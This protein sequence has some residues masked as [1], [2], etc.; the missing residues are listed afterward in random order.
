M[1]IL[2]YW[3]SCEYILR[4]FMKYFVIEI[5]FLH[6]YK[7]FSNNDPACSIPFFFFNISELQFR[8]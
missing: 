8:K 3:T 7:K 1:Y 4:R 5:N 2:L 6:F